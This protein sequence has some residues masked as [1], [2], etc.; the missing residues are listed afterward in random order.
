[1]FCTK[2]SIFTLPIIL[3]QLLTLSGCGG[4]GSSSDSPTVNPTTALIE[5]NFATNFSD[6]NTAVIAAIQGCTRQYGGGS[7][8]AVSC[9]VSAKESLVQNFLN[10]VLVNITAINKNTPIDKIAIS[11]LFSTYQKYDIDWLITYS[12]S[13]DGLAGS[14]S[15]AYTSTINVYY[16]NAILQMNAL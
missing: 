13:T 15:P 16:T 5:S 2:V 12:T 14:L 4:G 11:T 3:I 1:M 7:G 9:S 8:G 10:I 6:E